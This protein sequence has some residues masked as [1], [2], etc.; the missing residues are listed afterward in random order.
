M[1]NGNEIQIADYEVAEGQEINLR[2]YWE[3]IR[4]RK[5]TVLSVALGVFVLG[6]FWTFIQKP[7]YTAKSTLLIEKE[8]NILSFEQVLQIDSMRDDFYQTQY[9]L[10][11]GRGLADS[12]VE[13]LKLYE[14]TEFIGKPGKRKKPVDPTNHVFREDLVDD[15][16][17]RL[18]VKPVRLTRLVEVAFEAH[19]PK[20][21][22]DCVNELAASF[23]DLN[24][25]M[26]YAATEQATTFLTE[27][28]KGL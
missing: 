7:L 20:L 17:K 5:G 16:L 4:Q 1:K 26:K 23:I 15:F 25:N 21:A 6:T 14:N 22:A 12:V 9:K 10:L 11:S 28:I 8:P 24:I 2:D 3:K 19:D 13:R 27:Q 18:S